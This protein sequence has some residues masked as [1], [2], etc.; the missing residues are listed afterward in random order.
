MIDFDMDLQ[1]MILTIRPSGPLSAHDFRLIARRVDSVITKMGELPGLIVYGKSFP[2]WANFASML[3]HFRFIRDHHRLIKKVAVVSDAAALNIFPQITAH[4]I[5]AKL[6][7]F[8]Y[9]D[10]DAALDWIAEPEESHG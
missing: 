1:N 4:F 7:H 8:H 9:S 2:G 3:S 5:R 10:Y 6:K